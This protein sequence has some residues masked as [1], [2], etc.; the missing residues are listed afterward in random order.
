MKILPFGVIPMFVDGAG[1]GD[2]FGATGAQIR[3]FDVFYVNPPVVGFQVTGSP[4]EP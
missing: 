4:E 3:Y 1:I 2:N